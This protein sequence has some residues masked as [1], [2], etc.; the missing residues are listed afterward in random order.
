MVKVISNKDPAGMALVFDKDEIP[1]VK[2]VIMSVIT[3]ERHVCTYNTD[4]FTFINTDEE[5]TTEIPWQDAIDQV[6][7]RIIKIDWSG[8]E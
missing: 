8:N 6:Y 7:W 1:N 3:Q 2:F 5:I 4:T